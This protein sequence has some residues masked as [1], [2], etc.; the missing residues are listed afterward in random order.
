MKCRF[1]NREDQIIDEVIALGIK[2]SRTL[3]FM[4]EGAFYEHAKKGLIAVATDEDKLMGYVLFRV[5]QRKHKLAIAHLCVDKPYRKNKVAQT[6]LDFVKA[7]FEHHLDG[8]VLSCRRDFTEAASFWERYGFKVTNYQ[9][10]KSIIDNQLVKWY[11]NFGNNFL[12][13]QN[14]VIA[15]KEIPVSLDTNI[16]IKLRDHSVNNDVS[17]ETIEAT[18]LFADWLIPDVSYRFASETNNEINRSNNW[19]D[20]VNSRNILAKLKEINADVH[21]IR[22]LEIE[23]L[24]ILKGITPNDISDR[25]Q[26]A[27][28]IAARIEFFITFDNGILEKADE[29]YNNYKISVFRPA[30]FVVHFDQILNQA[31]YHPSRLAGAHYEE[32][33]ASADELEDL[34]DLFINKK[35]SEKKALFKQKVYSTAIDVRNNSINVVKAPNGDYTA[36]WGYSLSEKSVTIPFLRIRGELAAT[37]S[38]QLLANIVKKA[39]SLKKPFIIVEENYISNELT[40]QL[41]EY[42][43]FLKNGKW[44]KIALSGITSFNSLEDQYPF[45][46]DYNEINSAINKYRLLLELKEKVDILYNLE[47]A[48]F[49]VKFMEL[50]LPTYIVPIRSFWASQL[51]EY[52]LANGTIYGSRPDLSWNRENVYYRSPLPGNE[53]AAGR[54]LWYVSQDKKA[55]ERSKAITACSYLDDVVV[56]TVKNSFSRYKRFGVYEWKHILEKAGGDAFN[57]I[58]VLKFSDTEV[59]RRPITLKSVQNILDKEHTFVSPVEISNAV[60]HKI[61]SQGNL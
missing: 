13:N 5:V 30:E 18:S 59:F 24:S 49:P 15:E 61:Y 29:L 2:F 37:L 14:S 31:Q 42:G 16:I 6:L 26:L 45:I 17:D 19:Q 36:F 54:I 4:P 53:R 50:D 56:D 46:R 44:E 3:G 38:K 32:K 11:Y 22:K 60:F 1:I 20:I 7:K 52:I 43:F 35:Q 51:F 28:C 41:Q 47:R 10:S 57:K 9:K 39:V 48:L 21:E 23:L 40:N 33:K 34:I 12:F 55:P 58:K 25:R 27:E 8:M